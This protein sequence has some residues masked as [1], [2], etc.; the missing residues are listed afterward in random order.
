LLP[1]VTLIAAIDPM[2]FAKKYFYNFVENDI[3]KHPLDVVKDN[4]IYYKNTKSILKSFEKE[5]SEQECKREVFEKSL[6]KNSKRK[7]SSED[8]RE[9]KDKE[10]PVTQDDIDKK[11]QEF[12]DV[13][14]K[15]KFP[16]LEEM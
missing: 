14:P 9:K 10:K 11:R 16:D 7:L 2:E 4:I 5:V 6:E 13:V 8:D 15:I 12:S 1:N 3:Y